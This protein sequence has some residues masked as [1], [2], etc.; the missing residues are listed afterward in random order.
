MKLKAIHIKNFR[1]YQDQVDI[2][3]DDITTF[4]GKNDIG[5]STILEALEIFFN[6]ETVKIDPSDCNIHS[7]D[8]RVE[9]SC[10]FTNLPNSIIL[11][12]GAVTNLKDEY[13]LLDDETLRIKKVFDCSKTKV[14][15][16]TF[17]VAEHPTAKGYDDLL[18]TKESDL[19]KLVKQIDEKG[20]QKNNPKMRRYIW[21]SV[22]DLNI[23]LVDVPVAKAKEDT[24]SIWS[25]IES[26][27]P[28]FAL[29]QSDRT[30]QDSDGVVQNPMKMAIQ[31]AISDVQDDIDAIQQKI[32]EK[33]EN[34]AN[35]THKAL[36]ELSPT[37]ASQLF[38]KFSS[39][40]ASKWNSLY[41]ISMDTD[42]GIALNKR[43]SGV[44][45]MILVGFFKAEAERKAR[46]TNKKD[47]IY[48]IEEPE[49]A[50]HP[51]NQKI[52]I[53]SFLKLSQEEHC[54]VIITTHSPGL[55]KELPV[56]SIRFVNRDKKGKPIIEFG[57]NE[58][59]HKVVETLGLLADAVQDNQVKVVVCVEGPT[60]VIAM[61]SFSRCL[62]E[63]DSS[64]IDLENDPRVMVLPLGGS[65]LKYWVEQQYL[66]KLHVPVVHIYDRDVKKYKEEVDNVNAR[67]DG[68]WATLTEKYEIENYLHS[69]AIKETYGVVIDTSLQ[70][71]PENFAK[72]YSKEKGFDSVMKA[73]ASKRYLSKVFEN[74]MTYERLADINAVDEIKGWLEKITNLAKR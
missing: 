37:L 43:G 56:E 26:Y 23:K 46:T 48:A 22:E 73:N 29:F 9:I 69:D 44:R 24:K 72:V 15:S 65:I 74:A 1:C 30:S 63:K 68:S 51:N 50:Q 3:F 6:N 41:S 38:P 47:V 61:K 52:L 4:I 28:T 58:V 45:R 42:E 12:S 31:E 16:E 11:D 64:V 36:E 7:A 55:A 20:P 67:G 8:K 40:S 49:T 71:V 34:I 18:S 5:K 33:A 59:F 39:P 66:A 13:L 25:K 2:F 57:S 60:D 62:R 53:D 54:Q 32:K 70:K 21:N 17:I 19:Q 14:P 10:D 27:L 35:D